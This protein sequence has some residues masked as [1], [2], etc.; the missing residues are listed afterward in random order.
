MSFPLGHRSWV[1][2][3]VLLVGFAHSLWV[4]GHIGVTLVAFKLFCSSASWWSVQ[5]TTT[6]PVFSTDAEYP[7]GSFLRSLR[8]VRSNPES[9][10]GPFPVLLDPP[11]PLAP[12]D[13]PFPL[14]LV[15]P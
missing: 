14:P 4:P 5:T 8:N 1:V 13:R 6:L 12:P 15:T 9:G 7:S 11:V 10:S 2:G 3:R